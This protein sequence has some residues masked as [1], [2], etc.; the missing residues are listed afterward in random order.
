MQEKWQTFL[1]S[2]ETDIFGTGAGAWLILM[3][4]E[5]A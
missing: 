5:L 3:I 2:N 4:L 1:Y